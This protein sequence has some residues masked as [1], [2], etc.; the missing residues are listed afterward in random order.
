MRLNQTVLKEITSEYWTDAEAEA[1]ILWPPDM[2][3][4]L[5]GKDPGAGKD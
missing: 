5:I 4:R 1:S 2:K 3:I